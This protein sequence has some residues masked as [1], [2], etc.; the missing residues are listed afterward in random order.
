MG[1]QQRYYFVVLLSGLMHIFS[2][3]NGFLNSYI[4]SFLIM[5]KLEFSVWLPPKCYQGWIC[6][7]ITKIKSNENTRI[8]HSSLWKGQRRMGL[9]YSSSYIG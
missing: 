2:Y 6:K 8:V 1:L 3:I 5:F 4:F 7:K 9:C